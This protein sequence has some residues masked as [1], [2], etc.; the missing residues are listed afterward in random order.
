M[1]TK[2]VITGIGIVGGIVVA[3]ALFG[4]AVVVFGIAVAI[5]T[6][7]LVTFLWNKFINFWMDKLQVWVSK[8]LGEKICEVLGKIIAFLNKPFAIANKGLNAIKDAWNTLRDG[9]GCKTRYKKDGE[10][11]IIETRMVTS[12]E[13][14][15]VQKREQYYEL[16]A[17]TRTKLI[18]SDDT[19]YEVDNIDVFDRRIADVEAELSN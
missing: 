12:E 15:I 3:S 13:E 11:V 5:L 4:P 18:C 7:A 14:I 9:L 16:P 17:E 8:C 1:N 6:V 19:C 2:T 10:E